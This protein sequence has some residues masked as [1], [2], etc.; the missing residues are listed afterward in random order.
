MALKPGSS[1]PE[2]PSLDNITRVNHGLTQRAPVTPLLILC[3]VDLFQQKEH[4]K[5][6]V[7]GGTGTR[8]V[9][10]KENPL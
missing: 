9:R 3:L 6:E 1:P 8:C 7:K 2:R 10:R 4:D 5:A